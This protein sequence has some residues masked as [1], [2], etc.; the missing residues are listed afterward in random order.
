MRCFIGIDVSQYKSDFEQISY[1]N[2]IEL[3]RVRNYHLTFEFFRDLNESVAI[4]VANTLEKIDYQNL[5]VIFD[6]LMAYPDLKNPELYAITSPDEEKIISL[7]DQIR[8]EL[9]DII[10]LSNNFSPHIT[11]ARRKNL[12][13]NFKESRE[14]VKGVNPIPVLLNSVKLYVSQ[15]DKGLNTYS[16]LVL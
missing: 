7:R 3:E 5:N 16:A 4:R 2:T 10:T 14:I 12:S 9:S 1:A 8:E 6:T 13:P 15:P 11:I